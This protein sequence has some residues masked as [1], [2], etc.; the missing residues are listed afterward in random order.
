ME[1][2]VITE[3]P[4]PATTKPKRS[5]KRAPKAAKSPDAP[6][7]TRG[8]VRTLVAIVKERGVAHVEALRLLSRADPTF[9]DGLRG[10]LS[11]DDRRAAALKR[12]DRARN[13]LA[14]AE[15]ALAAMPRAASTP[16]MERLDA[17]AKSI[18]EATAKVEPQ[19]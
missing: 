10:E 8:P 1:Q 3:T 11:R 2:E 9:K 18:G 13:A 16:C 12:V 15:A 19:A 14:E 17:L 5:R 7:R 4:P 6:K